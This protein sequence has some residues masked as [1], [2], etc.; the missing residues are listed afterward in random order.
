MIICGPDYNVKNYNKYK[1]GSRNSAFQTITT[2]AIL[3]CAC[4]CELFRNPRVQLHVEE[5]QSTAGVNDAGRRVGLILILILLFHFTILCITL[6]AIFLS[7]P[8]VRAADPLEHRL[9]LIE[10]HL[11][12]R[13]L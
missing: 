10:V 11:R 13:L 1:V 6:L 7:R 5:D 4:L 2:H 8:L 9:A 3:E 12:Q